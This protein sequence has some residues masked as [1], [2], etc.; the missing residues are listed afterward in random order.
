MF[1]SRRSPIA[2]GLKIA[3]ALAVVLLGTLLVLLFYQT[4]VPL[5]GRLELWY[6]NSSDGWALVLPKGALAM[7]TFARPVSGVARSDDGLVVRQSDGRALLVSHDGS[8]WDAQPLSPDSID[9]KA[10]RLEKPGDL[11]AQLVLRR[12]W[13]VFALEVL[14]VGTIAFAGLMLKRPKQQDDDAIGQS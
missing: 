9:L 7:R 11:K 13:W 6:I 5:P 12:F 1:G 14:A 2:A 8:S 4:A 3:G 10:V